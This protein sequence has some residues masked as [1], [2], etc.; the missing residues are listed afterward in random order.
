ME[1]LAIFGILTILLGVSAKIKSIRAQ[2]AFTRVSGI[3]ISCTLQNENSVAAFPENAFV[4]EI[5]FSCDGQN[6]KTTIKQDKKILE[7]EKIDGFYDAVKDNFLT[8]ANMK[9][10][11]TGYFLMALGA[12][13][14]VIALIINN[15]GVSKFFGASKEATDWFLISIPLLFIGLIV[16]LISFLLEKGCIKTDG[17]IKEIICEFKG[18]DVIYYPL[19]LFSYNGEEISAKSMNGIS[20]PNAFKIGSKAVLLYNP[21]T[22]S[23]YS[24]RSKLIIRLI[25]CIVG[26]VGVII[27]VVSILTL[28]GIISPDILNFAEWNSNIK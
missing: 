26:T 3:V 16:F 23:I 8:D 1:N 10:G 15:T 21:R 6:I 28:S 13:L 4:V 24:R 20:I 11:T 9:N 19:Y 25:A 5:E 17:I 2:K 14:T 7:G 18:N 27:L 12:I 22:G